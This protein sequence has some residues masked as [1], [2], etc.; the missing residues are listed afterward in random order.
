MQARSVAKTV[1]GQKSVDLRS[2]YEK[3]SRAYQERKVRLKLQTLGFSPGL[4]GFIGK[5]I[6][7]LTKQVVTEV[8]PLVDVDPASHNDMNV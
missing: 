7:Y 5:R 2:Q 4:S 1:T 3:R 6:T 8:S